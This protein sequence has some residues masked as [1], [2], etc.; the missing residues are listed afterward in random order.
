MSEEAVRFYCALSHTSLGLIPLVL[1][2]LLSVAAYY[3]RRSWQN[4]RVRWKSSLLLTVIWALL[5][6]SIWFCLAGMFHV[7]CAVVKARSVECLS[8]LKQYGTALQMYAQDHD[9]AFPPA[10]NWEIALK[11][12]QKE[13]LR[14]PDAKAESGYGANRSALGL[15]QAKIDEPARL[16]QLFEIAAAGPSFV[17]GKRD[18][19]AKRH[20]GA[21]NVLF[22]DGHARSGNR[23][24]LSELL[25][26][27]AP[28]VSATPSPQ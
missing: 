13:P 8:N 2:I 7:G 12:Y 11:P 24:T 5:L 20:G 15:A 6:T 21:P 14:C 18:L 1:T 9:E 10:K 27:S 23:G 26:T 22:A 4:S 25:W 28:D 17:G 3:A 19:A 16:V